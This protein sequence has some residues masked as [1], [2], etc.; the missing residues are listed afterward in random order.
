MFLGTLSGPLF[1]HL[2][3]SSSASFTELILTGERAGKFKKIH[4]ILLPSENLSRKRRKYQFS[5]LRGVKEK[6]ER[7]L[8]VG[9]VMI[10]KSKSDQ[11]RANQPRTNQTRVER[12][13]RQFTR[14]NITPAQV[15]PH[16]LKLNLENLKEAP[17]NPEYYFSS[18]PSECQVRISF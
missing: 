14:I 5:I 18:L 1:N 10:Q 9:A 16:L 8:A 6:V 11:P 15:L 12:P 7:R 2:I 17:K 13:V 4:L 3:G